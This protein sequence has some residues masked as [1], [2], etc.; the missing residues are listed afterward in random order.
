VKLTLG[1]TTRPYTSV[2]LAEAC[3][4]IAQAGYTDVALFRNGG[5]DAASS[6]ADV[7]AVRDVVDDAGLV[8]SMVIASKNLEQGLPAAVAEYQRFLD[9]AALLGAT[10][11]LELGISQKELLDDYVSLM[12]AASAHA[13]QVGLQISAKPH[14][15][16]TTTTQDLLDV[17]HRIGHAAFGICYDPGN[18]IY[19]TQ[20][21]ERPLDH[22][23]EAAPLVTTGIIKDCI[24]RDG[25][26]D[27]MIT[28]G[29]GW[30]DFDGV[31]SALIAG[32]FTGP[33]YLECVGGQSIDEIDANV[34]RTRTMIEDILS[35]IP[36]PPT[37]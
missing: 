36:V 29:E 9:H 22:I 18:I 10:W 34:R 24:V 2:S 4:R 12:Q 33:L 35:H 27:V 5:I 20:G 7:L 17:Y 28:P 31:L 13:Q 19:Y 30:V 25:A 23:A 32:G 15:G 21:A 8:P 16:I 1:C 26:P 3:Q 37:S 11:I 6:Q 14:G